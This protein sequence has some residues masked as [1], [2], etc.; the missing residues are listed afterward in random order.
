MRVIDHWLQRWRASVA[1]PWIREGDRVLDVGCHQGEL[2]RRLR[3]RIGP[4]LGLDPLAEAYSDDVMRLVP[5]RFP[6]IAPLPSESFDVVVMLATLEHIVDKDIVAAECARVLRGRGR[7][8]ATVPSPKVDVLVGALR[9]LRVA[10][11]MSFEEHHGFDPRQTPG[12]FTPHGF[13]LI[14]QMRFQLGL[15]HL[16]VFQKTLS[17]RL[18]QS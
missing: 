10:D 3:G 17:A 9:R 7:I 11:G 5:D 1:T 2:L 8:V 6:S 12:T 18:I 16:F 4:S 13:E 15:N 14:H